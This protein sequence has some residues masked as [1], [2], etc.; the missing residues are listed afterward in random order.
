M[1]SDIIE[2]FVAGAEAPAKAIKGLSR[3]ELNA[4]PVP[5]TWSIQQ[6]I[7]HLMDSDL[8][9]IDRMKRIAAM[10][11]P[12]LI[13]YDENAYMKS[14]HP[15][16]V[17]VAMAAEAFRVNRLLLADVLRLL[18]AEA[19]ERWGVHNEKGK[20]TLGEMLEGYCDHLDH[21]LKFVAAKRK[22]LGKP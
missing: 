14:L 6:V 5:G 12:L 19:F 4:F 8:V 7:V 2:R 3:Q 18:P 16:R 22:A 20:V 21:H 1:V 15:D 9:G 13:G 10:D 11:R 17:D